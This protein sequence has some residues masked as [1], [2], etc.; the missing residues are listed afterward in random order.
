MMYNAIKSDKA[1]DLSQFPK[2][3]VSKFWLHIINNGIGEPIRIP[4][5]IARGTEDGPVL[6]LNAALH[7]NELNGI[8]V[9]QKLFREIG[10]APQING[11]VI[12]ILVANVPGVLLG[13][14]R[15]NDD[16]DLNRQAPGSETG[17]PSSIY[18]NR[19]IERVVKHFDYFL[20]L[21]TTGFGK[22]NCWHI[23]ADINDSVTR[24]LA[25]LQSPEAILH[26]TPDEQS[27]RG[28]ASSLG[29]KSLTLEI[30]DPMRFQ[31]EV[32]KDAIAGIHNLMSFIGMTEY[33]PTCPLDYTWLCKSSQ[34]VRSNEGGILTVFPELMQTVAKGEKIAE[35]RNIFGEK[36]KEFF[37]PE[38]G[39]VIAKNINPIAQT[40]SGILNLGTK[41][42][43][44]PCT[45]E[46]L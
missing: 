28:H 1:F 8:N 36:T 21:H 16:F 31:P 34:W 11:T 4:M 10:E 25:V 29:I 35:V 26:S 14:R 2:G 30:K 12:G 37:A 23:R 18:V 46:K 45:M 38:N 7:G 32:V 39:I 40:G 44:I 20:D 9:I 22:E 41:I 3:K 13:Q 33:V 19:L 6:G 24:Q 17:I 5:L 27:L 43:K 15:F 42:E